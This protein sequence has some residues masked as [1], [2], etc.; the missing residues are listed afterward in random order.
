MRIVCQKVEEM[1]NCHICRWTGKFI[2]QEMTGCPD[3]KK[4]RVKQH[5]FFL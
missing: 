3:K 5:A 4:D 1:N 2:S